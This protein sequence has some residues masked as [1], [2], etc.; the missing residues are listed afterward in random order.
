MRG[1]RAHEDRVGSRLARERDHRAV[2]R[3][4]REVGGAGVG[5]VA[6][7]DRV[8]GGVGARGQDR[9]RLGEGRV[10]IDHAGRRGDRP[11]APCLDDAR[12][13]LVLGGVRAPG[14][15]AR[16]R[17]AGDAGEHRLTVEQVGVG[18][19]VRRHAAARGDPLDRREPLEGHADAEPVVLARRGVRD[20]ER[21]L[22][23][24]PRRDR[25]RDAMLG[26]ADERPRRHRGE[27]W[28]DRVERLGGLREGG[29]RRGDERR[30]DQ[31]RASHT[32]RYHRH[33]GRPNSPRGRGNCL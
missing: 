4:R 12:V 2:V 11:G 18:R 10:L 32:S 33:P 14:Q 8:A 6:V 20:R 21:R 31:V 3:D 23:A 30:E 19:G 7:G 17:A 25:E 29:R 22:E 16:R 5:R 1:A 15:A 13:P 27:R 28:R 9:E 26:G 24:A